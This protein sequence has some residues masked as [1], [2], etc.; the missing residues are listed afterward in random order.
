MAFNESFP[1]LPSGVRDHLPATS[2]RLQ[3][4]QRVLRETFAR[5]GYAA[6][7]T[8][9]YEYVAV[10]ERGLGRLRRRETFKFVEPRT[11]EVVALRPDI[12]PQ[13]AR[14]FATRFRSTTLP[15]RLCYDG[16]VV[17]YAQDAV[18]ALEG[19]GVGEAGIRNGA[20]HR[21]AAPR[22]VFQAGVELL[23]AGGSDADAEVV[24]LLFA[25]LEAAGIRGAQVEVGHG[26]I[27]RA[28]L[29]RA[30]E[31][32]GARAAA[33][34][35]IARKDAAGL[36]ERCAASKVDP[37]DAKALAD[38]LGWFGRAAV[39][40][41]AAKAD[42]PEAAREAL[43]ELRAVV[44]LLEA[45]GL[46]EHVAVDLG[47]LRDLDYHD[48]ILFHAYA[49]GVA[50][51]VASGGRY[52]RLLERYGRRACATGFAI[53]LESVLEAEERQGAETG[54]GEV[55]RIL[56]RGQGG[57][58]SEICG[59]LRAEGCAV[60]RALA[61][62]STGAADAMFD[63]CVELSSGAGVRV[64]RASRVVW[65]GSATELD[66]ATLRAMLAVAADPKA[67]SP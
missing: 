64:L 46:G 40:D 47:E 7:I 16:R 54:A 18:F 51:A 41:A 56:V 5:W 67:V 8:P 29:G 19:E 55:P 21:E 15:Q 50:E 37:R 24:A 62:E 61:A 6:V 63:A 27:A 17:R 39:I 53:D 35:C 20:G 33:A 45:Q 43:E 1:L 25:A 48:G 42:L 36:E 2:A 22:E 32:P 59:A 52:D 26:E 65:S 9:L 44:R 10:L 34:A 57:G 13:I 60:V 66:A 28:L 3:A 31:D 23:D 58:L 4:L 49:P 12:T 38:L 30:F 11:G 14:L